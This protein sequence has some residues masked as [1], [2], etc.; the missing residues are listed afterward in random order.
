MERCSGPEATPGKYRINIK[1]SHLRQS[2]SR[3]VARVRS[4]ESSSPTQRCLKRM[5]KPYQMVRIQGNGVGDGKK[6]S[7][8]EKSAETTRTPD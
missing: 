2:R 3:H 1:M 4:A 6:K 5:P 7:E 8:S